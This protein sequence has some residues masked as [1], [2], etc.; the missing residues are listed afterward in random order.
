MPRTS[1]QASPLSA[2]AI[3]KASGRCLLHFLSVNLRLIRRFTAYRV[4]LGL[5]TAWRLAEGA[6]A[7]FTVFL[8][9][10]D[11]RGGERLR[12]LGSPLVVLFP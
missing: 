5:V 12:F 6:H 2:A 10:D 8:V 1:T 3:V 9:S 4:F 11:G 7:H